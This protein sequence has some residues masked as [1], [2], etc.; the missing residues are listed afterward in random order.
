[1]Q[2]GGGIMNNSH[3]ILTEVD[4][5]MRE[6]F[7]ELTALFTVLLC[8]WSLCLGARTYPIQPVVFS[9]GRLE[10]GHGAISA[11]SPAIIKHR[12]SVPSQ[13]SSPSSPSSR[14][15]IPLL[16]YSVDSDASPP[17]SFKQIKPI[18]VKA[19]CASAV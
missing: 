10:R 1:M 6:T 2:C 13:Q 19:D 18:H 8:V 5:K 12:V 11:Q 9:Q 14:A 4:N 3:G 16:S 15:Q 17:L 7:T